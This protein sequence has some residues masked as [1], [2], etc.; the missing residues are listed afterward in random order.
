MDLKRIRRPQHP[1]A[2]SPLDL[3]DTEDGAS[4]A[5]MEKRPSSGMLRLVIVLVGFLVLL[6]L[7]V[8]VSGFHRAL[9]LGHLQGLSERGIFEARTE[10]GTIFIWI[11][12]RM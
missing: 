5:P 10:Q 1:S 4:R 3:Q 7:L 6:P 8:F 11:L 9:P 12:K 2:T